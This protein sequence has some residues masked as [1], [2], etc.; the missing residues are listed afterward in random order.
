MDYDVVDCQNFPY[1][2]CFSAKLLCKLNKQD[3]FITWHEVWGDYWHEYLGQKGVIGKGVEKA[4]SRLTENNIAVSERTK[5]DLEALNI[6]GIHVVP[7]G[8]DFNEIERVK[9]SDTK[10]DV[11]Y[12]G[13]LVRHKNVDLLIKAVSLVAKGDSRRPSDSDRGWSRER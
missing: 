10:S 4:V 8:I 12:M 6:K 1:F 2:P 7:N 11:V 3:L 13:R 5:R 9:A